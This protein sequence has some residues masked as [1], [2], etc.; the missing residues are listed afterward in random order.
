MLDTATGS[1]TAGPAYYCLLCQIE[2]NDHS[3]RTRH[4]GHP[5]ALLA[6]TAA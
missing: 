2:S 6:P 4:A 5:V 3:F 1:W